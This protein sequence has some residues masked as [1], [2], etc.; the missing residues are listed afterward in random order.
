MTQELSEIGKYV[1]SE[2]KNLAACSWCK[3]IMTE[4]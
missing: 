1:P 4:T 3:L 2:N